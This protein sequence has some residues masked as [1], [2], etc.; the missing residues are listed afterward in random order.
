MLGTLTTTLKTPAF[1]VAGLFKSVTNTTFPRVPSFVIN[2]EPLP[3]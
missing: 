1:N 2:I 3:T